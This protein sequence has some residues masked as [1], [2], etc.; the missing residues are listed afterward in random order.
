MDNE[1]PPLSEIPLTQRKSF[2]NKNL[3]EG[4]DE[5]KTLRAEVAE[6]QWQLTEEELLRSGLSETKV[7]LE[8]QNQQLKKNNKKLIV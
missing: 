1:R 6:L 4:M 3:V 5:V 7:H 2:K 8:Q